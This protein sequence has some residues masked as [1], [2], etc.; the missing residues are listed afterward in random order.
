MFDGYFVPISFFYIILSSACFSAAALL[1]TSVSM[2]GT[3]EA[4][5]PVVVNN[6]DGE[7]WYTSI[8]QEALLQVCV[9]VRRLPR[10]KLCVFDGNPP[11]PPIMVIDGEALPDNDG[12]ANETCVPRICVLGVKWD[13]QSTMVL[14]RCIPTLPGIEDMVFREGFDDR[15][16][17]NVWPDPV[18]CLEVGDFSLTRRSTGFSGRLALQHLTFGSLFN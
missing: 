8:K 11:L 2:V 17:A 9:A 4:S 6:M 13:L 16:L 10:A 14:T 18:I 3:A 15:V 5:L 12:L 1:Y 7:R